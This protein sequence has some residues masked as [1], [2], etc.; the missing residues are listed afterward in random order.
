MNV[1]AVMTVMDV[2]HVMI[3][4]HLSQTVSLH[5]TQDLWTKKRISQKHDF[6]ELGEKKAIYEFFHLK[7]EKK[8]VS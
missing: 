7:T 1:T 8:G 4:N 5:T 6:S 3:G 2:K